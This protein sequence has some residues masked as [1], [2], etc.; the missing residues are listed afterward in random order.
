MEFRAQFQPEANPSRFQHPVNPA[1]KIGRDPLD[2]PIPIAHRVQAT[3]PE[4]F[5]LSGFGQSQFRV[6]PVGVTLP[7]FRQGAARRLAAAF[8]N[9][10]GGPGFV[11]QWRCP[12]RWRGPTNRFCLLGQGIGWRGAHFVRYSD[13]PPPTNGFS[14]EVLGHPI[15]ILLIDLVVETIRRKYPLGPSTRCALREANASLVA[16]KPLFPVSDFARRAGAEGPQ[17]SMGSSTLHKRSFAA[18]SAPFWKK[19]LLGLRSC[20]R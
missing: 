3:T 5:T 15:T 6:S 2:L 9:G 18:P 20:R 4:A 8:A 14:R 17:L 13:D 16:S 11:L 12:D 7:S 10:I 19:P 1:S